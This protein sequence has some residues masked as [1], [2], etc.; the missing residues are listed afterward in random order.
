MSLAAGSDERPPMW[1]A[2]VEAL[3]AWFLSAIAELIAILGITF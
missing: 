1:I 2:L 3:R